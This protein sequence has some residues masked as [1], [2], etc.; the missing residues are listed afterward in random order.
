MFD[1]H[2]GCSEIQMQTN[3]D[4]IQYFHFSAIEQRRGGGDTENSA[5]R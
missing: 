2:F 5:D 1:K 4:K 3:H